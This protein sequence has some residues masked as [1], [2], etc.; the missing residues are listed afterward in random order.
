MTLD[1]TYTIPYGNYPNH[2]PYCAQQYYGL[3]HSCYAKPYTTTTSYPPRTTTSYP[4]RDYLHE[5]NALNARMA[6]L[7]TRI[8]ELEKPLDEHIKAAQKKAR[9]AL[10]EA[11][12]TDE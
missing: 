12:E 6:E 8:K 3:Y 4:P 1:N 11:F 7:D 2:C 9:Q 5:I 10:E